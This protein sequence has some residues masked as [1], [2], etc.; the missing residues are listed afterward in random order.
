[1]TE[2]IL[3]KNQE[4]KRVRKDIDRLFDRFCTCFGVPEAM[5]KKEEAFSMGLS[6]TA[7]ALTL[8][9]QLPGMKRED[10]QVT[11]T[12][13]AVTIRGETA[14]ETVEEGAG[15]HRISSRSNLFSRTISLPA[16]VNV[17]HI[18]AIYKDDVLNILMPKRDPGD[19]RDKSIEIK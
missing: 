19:R 14:S 11:V 7:D 17:D 1:M 3:W 2:L 4:I 13:N 18:E 15:H 5:I 8:T 16:R 10:I 6:E 12:E 9:A